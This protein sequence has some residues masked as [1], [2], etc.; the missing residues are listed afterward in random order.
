VPSPELCSFWLREEEL[1]LISA[2]LAA[3]A[4]RRPAGSRWPMSPRCRLVIPSRPNAFRM[5]VESTMAGIGCRPAIALHDGVAAI[6]I[7]LTPA[8]RSRLLRG[9]TAARLTPTSR[10]A[11]SP[12]LASKLETPRHRSARPLTQ[13]AVLVLIRMPAKVSRKPKV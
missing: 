3:G 5:L 8:T 9:T 4:S 1:L 2:K 11:S 7:C 12:K 10:G 6:P 13:Q